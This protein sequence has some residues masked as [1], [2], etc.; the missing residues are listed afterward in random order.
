M[1]NLVRNAW[2]ARQP[3]GVGIVVIVFLLAFIILFAVGL[4][5]YEV[6]RVQAARDELR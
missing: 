3:R 2:N 6:H 1:K 5:T 4:F